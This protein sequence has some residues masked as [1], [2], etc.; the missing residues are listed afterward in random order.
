[1]KEYEIINNNK[2]VGT[3]KIYNDIENSSNSMIKSEKD[4]MYD[5]VNDIELQTYVISIIVNDEDELYDNISIFKKDDIFD[6]I[7]KIKKMN[8]IK[9]ISKN[10]KLDIVIPSI[11]LKYFNKDKNNVN[12]VSLF[13]SK[14]NFLK[15]VLKEVGG[16]ELKKNLNNIIISYNNYKN[17]NEYSFLEDEEK[18]KKIKEY[19]NEIDKIINYIENNT[20][21]K[22]GK[23]FITPIRID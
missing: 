22:Y 17:S 11:Y 1:M 12:I 8:N 2:K 13:H 23:I 21:Y 19:L 4:L 10:T 14:V 16:V 7:E 5:M 18:N 6:E 3:V 20:D 15:S 9:H